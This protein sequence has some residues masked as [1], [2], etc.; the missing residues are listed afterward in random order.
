MHSLV[1]D[2]AMVAAFMAV[3]EWVLPATGIAT[4]VVRLLLAAVFPLALLAVGGLNRGE[5][6]RGLRMISNRLPRQFRVR[7]AR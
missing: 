1:E 4:V 7:M 5:V 6:R 3:S 2:E